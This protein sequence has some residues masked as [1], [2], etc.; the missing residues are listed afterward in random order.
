[1]ELHNVG[2][3]HRDLRP[4][5]VMVRFKAGLEVKIVNLSSSA[6]LNEE[7]PV[8]GLSAKKFYLYKTAMWK[9]GSPN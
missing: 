2:I 7:D 5:N 1:M 8:A 4:E 3:V 6:S 9:S